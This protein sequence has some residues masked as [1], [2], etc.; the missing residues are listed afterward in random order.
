[1]RMHAASLTSVAPTDGF[2]EFAAVLTGVAR[3][4]RETG[5]SVLQP[6]PPDP[7]SGVA[8][9]CVPRFDENPE[10]ILID[11]D[12]LCRDSAVGAVT[13]N[14]RSRTSRA[15]SIFH[16]AR[17]SCCRKRRWRSAAA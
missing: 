12:G 3:P 1:M 5:I 15:R 6:V 9:C 14:T 8:D 11:S 10:R 7:T 4:M 16:S 13:S 2:G 17:S